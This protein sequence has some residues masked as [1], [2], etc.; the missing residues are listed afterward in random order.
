MMKMKRSE[1][2]SLISSK[3]CPHL[4]AINLVERIA[5]DVLKEIEKAGMRP[6]NWYNDEFGMY[7]PIQASENWDKENET[8]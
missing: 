6:P 2:I 1:M 8:E 3:I 7:D 5:Y 4:G